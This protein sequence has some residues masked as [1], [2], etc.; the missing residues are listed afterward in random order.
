MAKKYTLLGQL[1]IASE[2]LDFINSELLP[3]TGISKK[4]ILDGFR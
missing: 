3:G 1:S 2:L 4:K